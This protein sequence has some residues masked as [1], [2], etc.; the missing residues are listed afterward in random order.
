MPSPPVSMLALALVAATSARAQLTQVEVT[1]GRIA[2]TAV[3]GISGFKGIPFAAPPVGELR[4]K[5]P[6][7]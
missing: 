6:S 7:R 1:G 4:W 2:G 5:H 3:D